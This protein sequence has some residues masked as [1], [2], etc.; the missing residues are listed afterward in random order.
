MTIICDHAGTEHCKLKEY[1]NH[2][3]P[4]ELEKYDCEYAVQCNDIKVKCIEVKEKI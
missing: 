4:H 1:C 2:F 3:N